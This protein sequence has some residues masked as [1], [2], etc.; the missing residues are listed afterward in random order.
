MTTSAITLYGTTIGKKVAMAISGLV[1]VGWLLLHMLGNITIFAG[2]EA[3]NKYAAILADNPA[4]LWGQRVIVLA[5]LGTHIHAAVSL[6]AHNASAR[7][8]AYNRR[9][10]LATNY[11]ALTMKY[12]G[13][14]LLAYILYHFAHLTLG[15]TG[16][17]FVKGDVYNNLVLGF[18]NPAIAGF[19]VLAQCALALHLFHGIWSLTQTLGVEHPKYNALRK[20]VA[21]ALTAIIVGGFLAIPIAVQAGALQPVVVDDAALEIAT[22]GEGETEEGS[23]P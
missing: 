1:V 4:L 10:D 15:V 18:Q 20:Q 6:L 22:D 17:P 19:Y 8:V 12:G 11:A 14:T 23:E 16:A 7:P 13:F 5:A 3:V 21:A 9:K 2:R